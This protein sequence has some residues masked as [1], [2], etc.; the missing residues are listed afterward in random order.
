M[1]VCSNPNC[2]A[3][4]TGMTWCQSCGS[5][6][7]AASDESGL[8]AGTTSATSSR[9]GIVIAV[10]AGSVG[11]AAL[12]GL[13]IALTAGNASEE[14]VDAAVVRPPVAEPASDGTTSAP[15]VVPPSAVAPVPTSTPAPPS[16]QTWEPMVNQPGILKTSV[17]SD[18]MAQYI[19][20]QHAAGLIGPAGE[21]LTSPANGMKYL[22]GCTPAQQPRTTY[23][24]CVELDNQDGGALDAG[25][26]VLG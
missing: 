9:R 20:Q 14:T 26:V 1:S 22:I 7:E 2:G 25:I 12:G 4:T 8:D 21:W 19:A 10:A 6:V 3:N 13:G 11:V 5:T 15:A 16:G 23:T 24:A 17:T 18:A